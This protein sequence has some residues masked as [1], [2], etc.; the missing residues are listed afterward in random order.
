MGRVVLILAAVSISLGR[1]L[2][3]ATSQPSEVCPLD[4]QRSYIMASISK[5]EPGGAT[6]FCKISGV[7]KRGSISLGGEIQIAGVTYLCVVPGKRVLYITSGGTASRPGKG[8]ISE[9]QI[10][11]DVTLKPNAAYDI[12]ITRTGDTIHLSVPEHNSAVSVDTWVEFPLGTIYP[13]ELF[14]GMYGRTTFFVTTEPAL[15]EAG[16]PR[17][18]LPMGAYSCVY[19]DNDYFF[20]SSSKKAAFKNEKGALEKIGGICVSKEDGLVGL[21]IIAQSDA[22]GTDGNATVQRSASEIEAV[23]PYQVIRISQEEVRK[24]PATVH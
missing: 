6:E 18:V 5:R 22:S 7:D 8:K 24:W 23:P 16:I 11:F 4:P 13:G 14:P 2:A 3:S 9:G 21:Y 10:D 20:Y 12:S 19:Q 1:A 15:Q 17:V